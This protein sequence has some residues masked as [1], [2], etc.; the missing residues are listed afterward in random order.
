MRDALG[1][2]Q[3]VVVV[4]A[5]RPLTEQV[6]DRWSRT[7]RGLAV[8][9][10]ELAP[11]GASDGPRTGGQGTEGQG[12]DGQGTDGQRSALAEAF[13]ADGD[14]DVVVVTAAEPTT[15]ATRSSDGDAADG[16]RWWADAQ[17]A[18]AMVDADVRAPITVAV[19]AVDCLRAQGH[20]AL[21]WLA[22]PATGDSLASAHV[23]VVE[24]HLRA[25]GK[26]VG[27]DGVQVLIVRPDPTG[28]ASVEELAEAV[29]E[30]L[31][32]GSDVVGGTP[33]V[34]RVVSGLRDL[35]GQVLRRDRG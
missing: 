24:Q 35:S 30:G 11:P 10:V 25:L 21:V 19:E 17:S 14:V 12:T 16:Q 15:E 9:H 20:G 33:Q 6:L 18:G 31:R 28:T 4:G 22:A 7:S 1:R 32:S 3:R 29:D 8:D 27:P 26:Q 23:A 13:A 5:T 34:R 2:M